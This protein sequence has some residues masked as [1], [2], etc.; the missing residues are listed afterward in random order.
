ML[1]TP[2]SIQQ[3]AKWEKHL[4]STS[5]VLSNNVLLL[6]RQDFS[7][8]KMF[9]SVKG[10]THLNWFQG[11]WPSDVMNSLH[12]NWPFSIIIDPTRHISVE[13]M[14]GLEM[15]HVENCSLFRY[16]YISS[17][18]FNCSFYSDS[19]VGGFNIFRSF[20]CSAQFFTVSF[21]CY[22]LFWHQFLYMQVLSFL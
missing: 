18:F 5:V 22:L 4:R 21:Q 19:F 20:S 11:A 6:I 8:K 2:P 3:F 9:V 7:G 10:S 12:Y 1:N 15:G 16:Q 13:T 14:E 17:L